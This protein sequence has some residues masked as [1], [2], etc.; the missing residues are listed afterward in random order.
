MTNAEKNLWAKVH[1]K[2]R[3]SIKRFKAIAELLMVLFEQNPERAVEIRLELR[4][5]LGI[6]GARE[7]DQYTG[8]ILNLIDA[9]KHLYP[10]WVPWTRR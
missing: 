8:N 3:G 5:E 9:D 1:L 10:E 4:T 7:V 2:E 6:R